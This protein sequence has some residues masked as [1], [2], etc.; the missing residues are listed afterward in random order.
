MSAAKTSPSLLS[1]T[2][3]RFATPRSAAVVIVV[4][5]LL[6]SFL[7]AAMP[8]VLNDVLQ[9]EITFQIDRLP[10][11]VRDLSASAEPVPDDF[12]ATANTELTTAWTDGSAQI[13]GGLAERLEEIRADAAPSVQAITAPAEFA[14]YTGAFNVMLDAAL[15]KT[16]GS[17]P[18]LQTVGDPTMREYLSLTAGEWPAPWNKTVEQRSISLSAGDAPAESEIEELTIPIEIVL[19]TEG[20]SELE[21][22]IGERRSVFVNFRGGGTLRFWFTLSGI[23]DVTDPDAPRWAHLPV[24]APN[25][26][27]VDDGNS[28]RR[29]TAAGWVDPGSWANIR[30]LTSMIGVR[31]SSDSIAIQPLSS[32]LT[33]WYPVS[34]Q[35][36]LQQNPEDLLAGLRQLTGQSLALNTAGDVRGRFESRVPEVLETSIGRGHAT[37]MTLAVAAVGPVAVSLALIV[38]AAGLIIR[39]RRT[40]L[41]LLSARGT[42]IGRLRQLLVI[43][44]LLLG[45]IPAVAGTATALALTNRSAGALPTVL[46]LAVGFVPALAL[47]LSLRAHTLDGDRADLDAPVRNRWVRLVEWVVLLIAAVAVGLMV[48]RGVGRST[49]GVDPLLIAAPLLATVALGLLAV[50]LHPLWLSGALR[51]AQRSTKVVPLIGTARSLRDPAAGTTAVLAMLVA[52]AIAVF[53]SL[54]LATVDRGAVAAAE[55]QVGADLSLSGPVFSAETID[56][57]KQLDG[58][59]GAVGLYAAGRENIDS[60]SAMLLVTDVAGLNAVQQGFVDALPASITPG[61]SPYDVVVSAD[62]AEKTGVGATSDLF[63]GVEIVGSADTVAG[64]TSGSPFI[65]MDE[66]DYADATGAQVHARKLLIK[67]DSAADAAAVVEEIRNAVPGSY[68][69]Q[70]RVEQTTAI[71]QSPAVTALRLALIGALILAVVLSVIAILLVAG[72]SRDARS[73]VVALLRTMGL[74]KKQGRSVVIWEFMPLGISALVGGLI[75]GIVLPLLVL[76]SIDLRPFTGGNKQ[77]GL[78]IDPVLTASLIIAVII[79]LALAVVAGVLAART[80]SLVTVLRTEEER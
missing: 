64:S 20:A 37:T 63:G 73:R 53:S 32:A 23:A 66:Q 72:V 26:S 19:T 70:S 76:Q 11:T 17:I 13:F 35:A 65:L 21:W 58:V 16:T 45:V 3:R 47:A 48:F 78:T 29:A 56:Q 18:L 38:L 27:V 12:G 2:K 43:E 80:T 60:T 9:D 51:A 36:T 28:P 77:P 61:A 25:P 14:A 68:A 49:S 57:V 52:V 31:K 75:L 69:V 10:E 41:L 71:Q 74:S 39:R 67:L 6:S 55:R 33:T 44:G 8:R 15:N 59:A 7:I 1:L 50:R 62:L 34:P 5:T 40:D 54:I 42:S 46:A 22:E 4:L 79:A 24:A 30:A